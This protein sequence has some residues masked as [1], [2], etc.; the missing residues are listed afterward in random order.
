MEAYTFTV[1]AQLDE[2]LLADAIAVSFDNSDV[3]AEINKN[4]NGS[5]TVVIG[6]NTTDSDP[7]NFDTVYIDITAVEEAWG[8]HKLVSIF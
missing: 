8:V 2:G 4:Q 5:F 3:T 6:S 7:V 1:T